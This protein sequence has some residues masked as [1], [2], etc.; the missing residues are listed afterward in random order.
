MGACLTEA[1]AV[2]PPSQRTYWATGWN[3]APSTLEA[4]APVQGAERAPALGGLGW[5]DRTGQRETRGLSFP[6]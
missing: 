2:G 5:G 6:P 3:L 1:P 4:E